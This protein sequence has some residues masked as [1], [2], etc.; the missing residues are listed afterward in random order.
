M[1][2]NSVNYHKNRTVWEPDPRLQIK[3]WR[4]K[5]L[6]TAIYI[7]VST[8]SEDQLNSLEGQRSYYMNLV[9]SNPKW[10]FVGLYVDEGLSGTSTKKRDG[11]NRLLD[12]C[13]DGK[14]D[15][16]VVKDVSRF[17]RN[18]VDCL[19]SAQDLMRLT[20]PVGIYFDTINLST[21][22]IGAGLII[23][24]FAMVAQMDSEMKS[25]NVKIGIESKKNDGKYMCP[26]YSLL[27]FDKVQKYEMIVEP[28]GAKAI[29]LIYKLFLSG[30]SVVEITEIMMRLG[31][32]TGAD[33]LKWST[34]TVRN[35]LRNERYCG[36]ITVQKGFTKDIFTQQKVK[37]TGE[38]R[39]IYE[40]DHHEAIISRAEHE[41]AILLLKANW[42]SPCFNLKYEIE[43][44]RKGILSGFIPLNIAFGWYEAGYY[45][46]AFES[47]EPDIPKLI[48][49]EKEDPIRI[50]QNVSSEMLNSNDNACI[51]ISKN[52]IMFNRHCVQFMDFTH[53]EL[54]LHPSELLLALRKSTS[55]NPNA[56]PLCDKSMPS[57]VSKMIYDLMG[58][59]WDFRHRVIAD[60]F[61]KNG[62]SV[63]FFNLSC[64]QYCA[65]HKRL[66]TQEWLDALDQTPNRRM[67]FKR[68]L[69]AR[70]LDDW[71][72]G[73]KATP[74]KE[75]NS[76]VPKTSMAKLEELA[77]EVEDLYVDWQPR[78]KAT[79]DGDK[80]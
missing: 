42:R 7:R 14:I 57:Y 37:N 8:D 48:L 12:D 50:P 23:P 39:M 33:K 71:K 46:G 38:R 24:I 9:N 11:F 72:V 16:V 1:N 30:I 76:V 35:I 44:V 73:E 60:I 17:A 45:L 75:F 13:K 49:D 58:W 51:S 27:G 63:L 74:V 18:T 52:T 77:R 67:M 69:L 26:T 65:N 3:N 10:E 79:E 32:P 19:T 43:V 29:Q 54:L 62:E 25:E 36:D 78:K 22:D 31:V 55:R 40:Q 59:R 47:A 34:Q 70:K 68:L 21:L 80:I 53:V 28:R 64:S 4:D 5:I 20:P 61:E 2:N 66:L 56:I 41:R 15:L 6:R